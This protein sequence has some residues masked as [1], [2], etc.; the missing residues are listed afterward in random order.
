M[1]RLTIIYMIMT[2][3]AAAI[4]ASAGIQPGKKPLYDKYE[5]QLA[6]TTSA[7]DSV[8]ILYYL[9]DLSDRRGQK[10]LAWD[11]YFT[12]GRAENVTAQLDMLRNLATFNAADDSV[13]NRLLSLTDEVSNEYSR[14][15]TRTFILN[16]QLSRKSRRPDDTSFQK[17]LLDSITKS[18]DLEGSDIYDKMS[19]LYQIIQYLG[20]DADGVLFKECL[21]RYGA[22][23]EQLPAS[24]YPLKNQ[25]YTTAAIVHS[26]M[27]GN[28]Q[29]AIMYDRKLLEIMDQLQQ[30]YTKKN[31]KFRNYDVN[32]FISYRRILSNYPGL[33]KE[34]I[35]EVTDSIQA[36]YE[37]D[38]DVKMTM[39]TNNQAFAFSYMAKGDYEKAIP[40]LKGVLKNADL[41]AYQKQKYN[42]MLIEAGKQSG[43]TQT[44]IEAMEQYIVHSHEIDSLRKI[45][46]RREI[47]LRDTILMAPL[48]YQDKRYE[49]ERELQYGRKGSEVT[50]M[51]VA[52]VLAI[53]LLIYAYLYFKLRLKKTKERI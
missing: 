34:E 14:S 41:S 3:L 19:L 49:N 5:K 52:G 17:M 50:L 24:D 38:S 40:A 22:L 15:A 35:K 16:Q 10:K 23:V 31:R 29:K 1:R 13:I 47:M 21:D 12:A 4:S 44:Y 8:R 25:Y 46:M 20:V 6:T 37:R 11:I 43:D 45:S 30:M 36:L 18:H 7:R 39:E 32:R 26:R 51:V 42:S 27:N 48:L 53:L 2:M 28:P 33:T 9:Y